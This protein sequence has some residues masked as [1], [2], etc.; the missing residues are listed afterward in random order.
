VGHRAPTSIETLINEALAALAPS[1]DEASAVVETEI[2]PNLPPILADRT[3]L[4]SS[5]QNLIGNALKYG[6][7]DKWLRV[8][9]H[10]DRPSGGDKVRVTVSDH[11]LG[12]SSKDLPHI[13]EPF[14]RG[15]EAESLQIRG[16]GLGLSIVKGIVEAHGGKV[17]VESAEGRGSTFVVLLPIIEGPL[18][19]EGTIVSPAGAPVRG[20]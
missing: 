17:R 9:A 6:G 7:S 4:R 2:A 20:A 5:I 18:P 11:G 15:A 12:I 13:F 8:E 10:L 3:A 1:I 14:Y 19:S 16:N